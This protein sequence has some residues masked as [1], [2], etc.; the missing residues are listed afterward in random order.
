MKLGGSRR[1]VSR[2]Q[3]RKWI[4]PSAL[5]AAILSL[6]AAGA[7]LWFGPISVEVAQARR[8]AA[9]DAVYGSGT[10]EPTVMFPIAPKVAARLQQLFA[11]EN[12][13]VRQGQV[14]AQLDN[15]ELAA[16]VAEWEARTRYAE[17][18]FRR[19]DELFRNGT[20]TAAARDQARNEL[21][22]ARAALDR[23]R[24][25]LAEM[26]LVAPA[27]GIIIRRDGEVGQLMS[28]GQE[29]FWMSCC[30]ALRVAAEIDEEDI[31]AVRPGQKVLIR[32]D[33]FPDRP[34]EGVV[35]EITP[36]GDPVQRT[37][38]V[39]IKLPADTPLMIGMTAD[40]NIIVGER[41]DALLVPSSAVV[42]RK[43][44]LAHDGRLVSRAVTVGVVGDRLT[45]IKSG[46]DVGDLVVAAPGTGLREGRAVRIRPGA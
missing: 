46:V 23:W 27:D 30:D 21:D 10:V 42:D 7:W 37:F 28:A 40:C 32:A 16:A 14:L 26:T 45:E 34:L 33:A 6:G 22:T 12:A 4:I 13:S 18:Q 15:R 1:V 9:V 24:K 3:M 39:R 8:G 25:Q 29:V 20:A 36:K 44:W 5:I 17:A 38:R 35:A 31:P 19:A 43:V 11:D 41:K 2:I